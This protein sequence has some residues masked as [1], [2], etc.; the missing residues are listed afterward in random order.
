[1]SMNKQNNGISFLND[2]VVFDTYKDG[3]PISDFCLKSE[4]SGIVAKCKAKH[5]KLMDGTMFYK[6]RNMDD[7]DIPIV[8]K[9]AQSICVKRNHSEL[10]DIVG[11]IRDSFVHNF[12]QE[13]CKME[14]V[15]ETFKDVCQQI[16]N[17]CIT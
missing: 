14:P 11:D 16:V 13:L 3:S 10:S 8:A 2:Y 4:Q 12:G 9:I 1:M 15:I 17:L 7:Y 6:L 5:Y